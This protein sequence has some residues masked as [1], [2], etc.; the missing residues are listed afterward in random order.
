MYLIENLG[1]NK[2]LAEDKT[3]AG[4]YHE[5]C[6]LIVFEELCFKM[7]CF[8]FSNSYGLKSIFGK[9]RFHDGL[10]WRVGQ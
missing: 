7:F 4:K 3:L 10:V 8:A 1:K 5:C 6:H 9:L 2:L